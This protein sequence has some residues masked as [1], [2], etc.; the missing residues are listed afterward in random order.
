MHEGL[1]K[2]LAV[3]CG[4]PGVMILTDSNMRAR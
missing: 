4:V 2:A 1:S 3:V